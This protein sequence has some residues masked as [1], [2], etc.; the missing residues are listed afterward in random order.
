V[1][2]ADVVVDLHGGDLDEDLRPY[3][4][5]FRGGRAAQDSAGLRLALA[6]GLDHIIVTD[7][8]PNAPNAGR[9]LS[10]QALVRGKT[11]LVAEAGRSGT[12]AP[13]DLNALVEGSLNVLGELKMLARPVSRVQHPTWLA[14]AGA[15]VAADSAGVFFPAVA[16]DTRVTKGQIVGHT[17]DFVGRPTGDVRAPT[18][19]LVTFIRGVPSM[20]PRATLVNIAPVLK[21]P[22]QW[23]APK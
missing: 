7:V 17:T 5:W 18:D 12:V 19:G 8:D 20:W 22:G 13:A 10:G 2:P 3:S 16:R 14:G 4:Y 21:D 6:F 1:T 23:T 9:S 11:V 15:R